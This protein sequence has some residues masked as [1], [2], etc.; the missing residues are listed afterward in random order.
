[1]VTLGSFSWPSSGAVDQSSA[2][3]LKNLLE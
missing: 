1:L 3:R 2:T